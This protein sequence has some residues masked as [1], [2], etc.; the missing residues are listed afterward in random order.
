M[1]SLQAEVTGPGGELP[2]EY[3]QRGREAEGPE[4]AHPAV[5][6]PHTI[7]QGYR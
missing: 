3:P 4:Q 5:K 1:S 7:A 6:Q 2:G